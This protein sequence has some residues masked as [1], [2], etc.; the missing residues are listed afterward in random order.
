LF[1]ANPAIFQLHHGENK[2]PVLDQNA[3]L[4]FYSASSIKQQSTCRHVTPL[5][6]IILISEPASALSP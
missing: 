5:G 1:N 2:I 3:Q 6:H 4:E